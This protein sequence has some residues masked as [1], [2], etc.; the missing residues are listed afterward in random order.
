MKGD[1]TPQT[2]KPSSF[3]QRARVWLARRT[4]LLI[5]ACL[6]AILLVVAAEAGLRLANLAVPTFRTIPLPEQMA[7][8]LQ[9]DEDLFWSVR[10]RIHVNYF[11][12]E[13]TTNS[14]GQR[15]PE[16]SP[17][18]PATFRILSL[19]ES[20]T[21]GVGVRDDETYSARLARELAESDPRR[22][23]EVINAGVPAYSS[24]QSLLY[25][26]L[27]GLSLEP[28]LVLFYHELNDY[29]PTSFREAG[30]SELDVTQSD[31]QRYYST[32]QQFARR[33][34]RYS[35]IFRYLAY[36]RASETIRE[37]QSQDLTVP[38][39]T[40]GLPDFST[41]PRPRLVQG[42]K[43]AAADAM[44]NERALPT[45]VTEDERRQILRQLVQLCRAHGVRL[46][47]IHPSY[48]DSQRHE[49]VLTE[50]CRNENV[51]MFEAYDSLHPGGARPGSRFWDLAHPTSEGHA[52]LARDLY[53][54][55]IGSGLVPRAD[56]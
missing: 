7:G 22:R 8:I 13:V 24:F 12:A 42:S 17:K 23:F 2:S 19:G 43:D 4:K 26:Q 56:T 6:P 36:H 40:I 16:L 10:P 28:D 3:P 20:T 5:F 54:F 27:R 37:M 50:T 38:W 44:L 55:L 18:S 32:R 34:L 53:R 45:R 25:L 35:A 1:R 52:A 31:R 33:L 11:G 49:C 15:S 41:T 9:L 39:S 51:P 14:L 21:F 47:I 46:I 29:L 30:S 48:R